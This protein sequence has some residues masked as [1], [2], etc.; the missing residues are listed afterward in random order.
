MA[1]DLAERA[2]SKGFS[3]RSKRKLRAA[4]ACQ[5]L[6]FCVQPMP[7]QPQRPQKQPQWNPRLAQHVLA[8]PDSP[9]L[10]FEGSCEWGWSR[11]LIQIKFEAPTDR[12]RAG[13][14]GSEVGLKEMGG[15]QACVRRSDG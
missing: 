11:A 5:S 13:L 10:R 3:L 4:M 1:Q 12:R 6:V 8:W 14:G 9:N 15:L 2:M 7:E